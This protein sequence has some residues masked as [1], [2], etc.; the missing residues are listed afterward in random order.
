M[1]TAVV[2]VWWFILAVVLAQSVTAE[3]RG[4][5]WVFNKP[6][7]IILNGLLPIR[8]HYDKGF[9]LNFEGVTWLGAMVQTVHEINQKKLL[10]RNLTL[11]YAI[12]DTASDVKI[13]LRQTLSLL[14][15][16]VNKDGKENEAGHVPV[17]MGPATDELESSSD[18]LYK[19]FDVP[20]LTYTTTSV[21]F[22]YTTKRIQIVPPDVIHIEALLRILNDMKVR[23]FSVVAVKSNV[24]EGRLN[25]LKAALKERKSGYKLKDIAYLN[26]IDGDITAVKRRLS[27]KVVIIFAGANISRSIIAKGI[28][29]ETTLDRKWIEVCESDDPLLRIFDPFGKLTEKV[30][31]RNLRSNA[32]DNYR[33]NTRDKLYSR[34][35]KV[36]KPHWLRKVFEKHCLKSKI[37]PSHNESRF[38]ENCKGFEAKIISAIGHHNRFRS[39]LTLQGVIDAINLITAALK[40]T[41]EKCDASSPR[42]CLKS[43]GSALFDK[44]KNK[45]NDFSNGYSI[46]V[47]RQ[48]EDTSILGRRVK[49]KRGWTFRKIREWR[50]TKSHVR[51]NV[52]LYWNNSTPSNNVIVDKNQINGVINSRSSDNDSC[53]HCGESLNQS[54]CVFVDVVISWTHTS[55]IVLYV[56]ESL[57]LLALLS[58]FVYFSQHRNSPIMILC[59]SWPDNVILAVLCVFCLLPMM[60]IGQMAPNRCMLLWPIVNTVFAFYTSLLLTKTL[61][62]QNLLKCE[63]ATDRPW[64]RIIFTAVITFAQVVIVASL[65]VFD[66]PSSTH[67][68]CSSRGTIT[69]CNVEGNFAIL[70]SMA[71]N[72]LL[73]CA[74][75]VL[76][77]VETLKQKQNFCRTENLVAVATVAWLSYTCL[78]V[79]EYFNIHVEHYLAVM[80]IQC[81]VYLVNSA[82]CL[83][84]IYIPT[85][86][87]VS[88]WLRQ[89]LR[90]KKNLT[91][92]KRAQV[93]SSKRQSSGPM[94]DSIFGANYLTDQLATPSGRHSGYYFD[95]RPP[96]GIT[97]MS[98]PTSLVRSVHEQTHVV[99]GYGRNGTISLNGAT[100]VESVPSV[101]WLEAPSQAH[102]ASS[103]YDN[104]SQAVEETAGELTPQELLHEISTYWERHRSSD[105]IA[106]G[107][108]EDN[109][110]MNKWPSLEKLR[111]SDL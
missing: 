70:C 38:N 103:S 93:M 63:V 5:L 46:Q 27:S 48:F 56:L 2:S 28:G 95:L 65:F 44:L 109:I 45:Q 75:F 102:S 33:T 91:S 110:E 97:D 24:W 8:N 37:L 90:Q 29:S 79:L 85:V 31:I 39:S 100:S 32:A 53:E 10:P 47:L 66:F 41:L 80:L 19:L 12:R 92:I 71:F 42:D 89:H 11:G 98:Y 82:V 64:R 9:G 6:G 34:G 3:Q 61:F 81:V 16:I 107:Q 111:A 49:V 69:L 108:N 22:S 59:Y 105:V 26:T 76:S 51:D 25:M 50:I 94:R 106:N 84:L 17:V 67:L 23:E 15:A 40:E 21:R 104:I 7:D 62:V 36:V 86:R 58:T 68:T 52:R 18:R 74:L 77:V 99:F 13:G 14:D 54:H 73:M 101:D 35:G 43:H 96:S 57:C 55:A 87:L 1:C 4:S 60:H 72:W 88:T 83:G 78:T 20:R 30:I